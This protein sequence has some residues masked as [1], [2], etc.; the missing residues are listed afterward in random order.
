MTRFKVRKE[1]QARETGEENQPRWGHSSL[2][3][4]VGLFGDLSVLA[5]LAVLFLTAVHSASQNG[6]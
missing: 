2:L 1:K 3:P 4:H 5:P 6:F